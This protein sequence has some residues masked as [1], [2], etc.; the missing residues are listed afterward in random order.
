MSQNIPCACGLPLSHYFPSNL[1]VLI[2]TYLHSPCR[3]SFYK[4][5][6]EKFAFHVFLDEKH[7]IVEDS[8][9]EFIQNPS[10]FTTGAYIKDLNNETVSPDRW[11]QIYFHIGKRKYFFNTCLSKN[12]GSFGIVQSYKS[13]ADALQKKFSRDNK[14]FLLGKILFRCKVH[15][16]IDEFNQIFEYF[17]AKVSSWVAAINTYDEIHR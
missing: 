4:T 10:N 2:Q 15:P 1:M 11:L 12:K 5:H 3:E 13:F 14:I 9:Q 8:E 6:Y 7:N 16:N 17:S